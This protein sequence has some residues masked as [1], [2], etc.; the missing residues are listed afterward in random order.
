MPRTQTKTTPALR[1]ARLIDALRNEM[2]AGYT[3]DFSQAW[4]DSGFRGC[5]VGLAALMWPSLRRAHRGCVIRDFSKLL[6][7]NEDQAFHV[8]GRDRG[9]H[10]DRTPAASI[11]PAM[12]ADA[13]EALDR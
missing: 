1:R 4:D 11:T 7:L 9:S 6:G 13:L 10:F 5:A 8:V 12:V 2:P 3:W